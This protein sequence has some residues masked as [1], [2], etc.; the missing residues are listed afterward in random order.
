VAFISL[1]DVSI[2]IPIYDISGSSL[3]KLLLGRAIGGRFGEAG[4]HVIVNALRNINFEAHDG[5]RI[6]LVGSNGS[7][8]TTL[9]RV[10]ADVYP[11][12][13]GIVH[14][15]GRV[16]PML[17]AALGMTI[18]AT[19]WE[20]IRICGMLWGLSR[21]QIEASIQEIADFTE[22]GDFLNVPVR[23]Y[24]MGMLLRLGF[25]VATLRDPEILLLDE[26]IG[27]GDASFFTKAYDRLLRLVDRSQIMVVAS[28]SDV[29]LRQLCNKAIWLKS[30][31][32][33]EYGEIGKV[34]DAYKMDGTQSIPAPPIAVGAA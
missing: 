30:G 31:Q 11:P 21:P 8:K 5:D 26:V 15:E 14:V 13:Q 7:G 3:K 9:L 33:M 19:G 17:D 25:A 1:K 27:V 6:A 12:T 10:L 18:D 34:L 22:L 24:S 23:T 16:S 32:L 29:I 2:D 20:N 28:H 4:S